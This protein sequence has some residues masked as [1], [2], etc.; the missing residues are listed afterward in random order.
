MIS[1]VSV[2]Y[3]ASICL[4]SFRFACLNSKM[5]WKQNVC[6]T[7]NWSISVLHSVTQGVCWGR[8]SF[9]FYMVSLGPPLCFPHIGPAMY[10]IS[11][12]IMVLNQVQGLSTFCRFPWKFQG[13][14]FYSALQ[15]Y[16]ALENGTNL[17]VACTIESRWYFCISSRSGLTSSSRLL[18]T[19]SR[20]LTAV[21]TTSFVI[22][23]ISES[24]TII[25]TWFCAHQFFSP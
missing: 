21:Q 1:A 13:S 19:R 12:F 22:I 7:Y 5:E 4:Y 18:V 10:C 2:A 24:N 11:V 16:V 23:S 3:L 15:I 20:T 17:T 25:N 8:G 9:S 6:T 14:Q